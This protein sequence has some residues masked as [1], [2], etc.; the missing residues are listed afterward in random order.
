MKIDFKLVNPVVII[1]WSLLPLWLIGGERLLSP[2]IIIFFAVFIYSNNVKSGRASIPKPLVWFTLFLLAYFISI[3]QITDVFR[4]LTF[5]WDFSLY[6]AFLCLIYIFYSSCH[7]IRDIEKVFS[8]VALFMIL[9]H[10]I[11][12]SYVI[13]GGWQFE[14]LIGYLLPESIKSTTMGRIIAIRSVGRE[15]FFF[16]VTNR[17]SSIFSTSIHYGAV[18]L[19]TFPIFLYKYL[20]INGKIRYIHLFFCYFSFASLVFA[21]ARTAIILTFILFIIIYILIFSI[22]FKK[23]SSGV[24]MSFIGAVISLTVICIL[25]L[26]LPSILIFIE[27]AFILS[28]AASY[29]HRLEIY[30]RSLSAI[31]EN[32]LF[33]YGTQL[34]VEDMF[35]PL[36]SHNW[37]MAIIFKH[38]FF[39]FLAFLIFYIGIL[40]RALYSANVFWKFRKLKY[41][42]III[43][44]T[45]PIYTL[46]TFTIEPIVDAIHLYILAMYC[47]SALVL[48]NLSIY[49]ENNSI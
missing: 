31:L 36:G 27:E 47:G 32:P 17:L 25:I 24:Y 22:K 48:Y 12:I 9:A 33:G 42:S 18:T 35:Y 6:I 29:D 10:T 49:Y 34:T 38:G 5:F 13:F 4:Y 23:I 16:G 44:T 39:G 1:I 19:L 7:T 15:L 11:A 43:A 21:Q 40:W 46:L 28:R 8:H 2:L 45:L 37:F 41:L 3:V 14:S 20:I 30:T 26:Y